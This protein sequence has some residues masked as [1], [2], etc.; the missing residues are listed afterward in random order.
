[1]SLPPVWGALGGVLLALAVATVCGWTVA[2]MFTAGVTGRE[3]FAWSFAAGLMVQA[4]GL[5]VVLAV[6]ARPSTPGVLGVELGIGVAALA[7]G[8]LRRR[9]AP[10]WFPARRQI[11]ALTVALAIV[12]GAAWALFLLT[13]VADSPWATDFLAVWGYKAKIVYEA[14]TVPARLFADPALDFAHPEYPLL[15]PLSLSAL[16]AAAGQWNEPA[17]SLLYPACALAT[18]LA[19]SGFLARRVSRVAGALAAALS[20]LC[21]FL[22]RPSNVGTAEIPFALAAVLLTVAASDFALEASAGET[23]R[24]AAAALFAASVKQE[25]ALLS[26]LLAAAVWWKLRPTEARRARSGGVALVLPVALHGVLQVVLRGHRPSRDFDLALLSPGRWGE[27]PARFGAALARLL[28]AD[29]LPASVPLLA[30]VVLLIA[31]RRGAADWLLGVLA[32]QL[33]G[34]VAAFTLSAYGPAY[35]VDAAFSRIATTLF[36]ALT[37][38]LAARAAPGSSAVSPV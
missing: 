27:L 34:Y 24:L 38:V 14:G 35:A 36:P 5:L 4:I 31:T 8:I 21:F 30:I 10:G 23:A 12:A 7:A 16:A 9:P 20:A 6:G 19:L 25:G 37:L 22:Y 13:A 3:K 15:V 11:D 32:L 28:V 26:V 2:R 18:L 29:V 17:L 1:M 33:L